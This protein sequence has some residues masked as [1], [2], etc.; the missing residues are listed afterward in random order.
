[1]KRSILQDIVTT[2]KHLRKKFK[3]LREELIRSD[4]ELK[5]NLKPITEPLY[6]LTSHLMK[7]TKEEYP[8]KGELTNKSVQNGYEITFINGT[9]TS[10]DEQ[11]PSSSTPI[12]YKQPP[13]ET[14]FESDDNDDDDDSEESKE[15]KTKLSASRMQK[16]LKS[17]PEGEK[18]LKYR[19]PTPIRHTQ[20]PIEKKFRS[21]DDDDGS[22]ES[23]E[24]KNKIICFSNAG[25]IK[26]DPRR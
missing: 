16:I 24:E 17:T 7:S 22:E 14:K 4:E 19:L 11:G 8:S 1:M 21:D 3:N 2:S 23:K 13:I 18:I 26:I 12:H 9:E 5:K 25:N 20:S 10:Y 15:D 6:Q